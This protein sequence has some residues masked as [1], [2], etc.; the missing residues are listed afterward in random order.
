MQRPDYLSS[1]KAEYAGRINSALVSRKVA[2]SILEQQHSVL[3]AF[4]FWVEKFCF[5]LPTGP[6][7]SPSENLPACWKNF[8]RT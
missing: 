1:N 8:S 5:A 2:F 6:H 7:L 4:N 3:E